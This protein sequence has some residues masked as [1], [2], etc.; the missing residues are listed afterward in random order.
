M[1]MALLSLLLTMPHIDPKHHL[2]GPTHGLLEPLPAPASTKQ[3]PARR[4]IE[5]TPC[6]ADSYESGY[7]L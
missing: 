1:S 3:R 6:L 2:K 4:G 5:G 7:L